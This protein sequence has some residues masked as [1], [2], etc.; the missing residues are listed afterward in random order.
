MSKLQPRYEWAG[1]VS[2]GM[3]FTALGWIV[4]LIADFLA[5]ATSSNWAQHTWFP[6]PNYH[7]NDGLFTALV[8][9]ITVG[10]LLRLF[11]VPRMKEPYYYLGPGDFDDETAEEIGLCFIAAIVAITICGIGLFMM[12]TWI[13]HLGASNWKTFNPITHSGGPIWYISMWQ[14]VVMGWS[15]LILGW[16][17]VNIVEI[18]RLSKDSDLE[19]VTTS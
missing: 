7:F 9:V 14:I 17:T 5:H 3:I 8:I 11:R 13:F 12:G 2:T 16:C 1:P 19:Q 6:N 15:F 18:E 10:L 4:W